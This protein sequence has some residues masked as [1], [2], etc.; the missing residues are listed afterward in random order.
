MNILAIT[1][2]EFGIAMAAVTLLPV[3]IMANAVIVHLIVRGAAKEL[4][5]C[6]SQIRERQ[7]DSILATDARIKVVEQQ[8][9]ERKTQLEIS[10]AV[11][12]LL[13]EVLVSDEHT[14]QAIAAHKALDEFNSI[15][16]HAAYQ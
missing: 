4:L 6:V 12:E 13:A 15:H 14:A 7:Y 5:K 1:D 16:Q 2:F 3:V 11:T 9:P 8:A 10:V